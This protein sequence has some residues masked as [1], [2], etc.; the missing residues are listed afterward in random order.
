MGVGVT[1]LVVKVKP[2]ESSSVFLEKT[3]RYDA[4]EH[5][6]RTLANMTADEY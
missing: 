3:M 2:F 4:Y 1:M 5:Y 6:E